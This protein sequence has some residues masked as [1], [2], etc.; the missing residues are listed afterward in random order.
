[1]LL[2]ANILLSCLLATG[3]SQSQ[4]TVSVYSGITWAEGVIHLGTEEVKLPLDAFQVVE[5]GKVLR[6]ERGWA[7]LQLWPNAFLWAGEGAVVRL[8]D[9]AIPA[10]QVRVDRGPV[11]IRIFALYPDTKKN[12]LTVRFGDAVLSAQKPGLYS[13]N[14]GQIRVYEGKADLQLAGISS[15][16]KRGMAAQA[17]A[18]LILSKFDTKASDLLYQI[19]ERRSDVIIQPVLQARA[20][21]IKQ[22]P[23]LA[24]VK[25]FSNTYEVRGPGGHSQAVSTYQGPGP[26]YSEGWIESQAKQFM[27]DMNQAKVP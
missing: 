5:Q 23:Q 8:E 7:E 26:G 20:R 25:P 2:A 12:I 6:V 24:A 3:A 16:L 22:M 13:L 11:L 21:A 15:K 10:M 17:A 14:A 27:Q 1:M 9:Q 19:A 18:P 4:N